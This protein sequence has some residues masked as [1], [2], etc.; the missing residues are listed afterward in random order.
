MLEEAKA[1]RKPTRYEFQPKDSLGIT[2][3]KTIFGMHKKSKDKLETLREY[4]RNRTQELLGIFSDVLDVID[5][6]N[7]MQKSMKKIRMTINNEGGAKILKTDCDHAVALNSNNHLPFLLDYYR[8]KRE[9]LLKLLEI[10]DLC[11]ST[12]DTTLLKS[13]KLVLDSRDEKSEYIASKINLSFTTDAW[14]SGK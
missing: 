13:V 8:G 9:T 10:L 2:F 14:L 3:C 7:S 12:Q 1:C 4:Y 6:Q 5:N 11:S